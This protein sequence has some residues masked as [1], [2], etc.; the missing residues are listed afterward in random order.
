MAKNDT[1]STQAKSILT[2]LSETGRRHWD[3]RRQD[4]TCKWP[5]GRW[6]SQGM[7][8]TEPRLACARAEPSISNWTQEKVTNHKYT[9]LRLRLPSSPLRLSLSPP[10]SLFLSLSLSLSLFLSPPSPSIVSLPPP[11]IFNFLIIS[12]C[13]LF[14][15]LPFLNPFPSRNPQTVTNNGNSYRQNILVS[16]YKKNAK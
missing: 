6:A 14:S 11:I 12:L 5:A 16:N 1:V 2:Y 4:H 7:W 8:L 10:P 3:A 13:Q 9:S 15:P